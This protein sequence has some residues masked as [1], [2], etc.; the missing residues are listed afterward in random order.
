VRTRL[1]ARC[2]LAPALGLSQYTHFPII[3]NS[4]SSND[5]RIRARPAP[6]VALFQI[7]VRINRGG[8]P[9]SGI[10][11]YMIVTIGEVEQFDPDLRWAGTL[12][13]QP[14]LFGSVAVSLS[15]GLLRLAHAPA[16]ARIGYRRRKLFGA[17][18]SAMSK[19][20]C[21]KPYVH[22]A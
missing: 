15:I 16:H 3:N 19:L 20:F 1:V 10:H 7:P 6:A 8:I 9:S 11:R 14:N 13:H 21:T 18:V 22:H 4:C 12:C 5:V 17:F 2:T